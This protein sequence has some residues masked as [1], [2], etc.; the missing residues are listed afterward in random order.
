MPL[1]IFYNAKVFAFVYR[2]FVLTKY[3]KDLKCKVLKSFKWLRKKFCLGIFNAEI[4]KFF[5][6]IYNV[7]L[8]EEL[9]KYFLIL[10][11]PWKFAFIPILIRPYKRLFHS[12]LI[13]PDIQNEN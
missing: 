2:S 3:V 1:L 13:S 6:N 11:V 8:V 10:I 7:P 4:V 5:L 9:L 12:I